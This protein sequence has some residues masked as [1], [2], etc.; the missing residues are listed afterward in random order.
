LS[1][2]RRRVQMAAQ[3]QHEPKAFTKVVK[4]AGITAE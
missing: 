2:P 1:V 4:Q 3:I